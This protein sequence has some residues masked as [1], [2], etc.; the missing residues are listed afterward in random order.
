MN[1]SFL[2]ELLLWCLVLNYAV[3][4]LWFI[5]FRFGHGWMF[6][7]HGAWFHLSRERFDGIHYLGMAIYKI[8]I[9]LFNLVPSVALSILSG[10]AS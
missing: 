1:P 7:L 3:L 5:A 4:F 10:H 6:R 8:G 2:R 9:L